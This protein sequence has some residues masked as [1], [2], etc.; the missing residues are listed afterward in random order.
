MM[1]PS[2]N[3]SGAAAAATEKCIVNDQMGPFIVLYVLVFVIGL[4]GNL[5]SLWTFIRS[6]RAEVGLLP[7]KMLGPATH[8]LRGVS[9]F[10][11]AP[12]LT[13]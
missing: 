2:S 11:S 6:P 8:C 9:V 7:T 5:L 13:G 12:M 1:F 10:I 3:T 4:P